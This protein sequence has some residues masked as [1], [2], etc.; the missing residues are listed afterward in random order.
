MCSGWLYGWYHN[1]TL[2]RRQTGIKERTMVS[3]LLVHRMH[4][5]HSQYIEQI[6]LRDWMEKY[7]CIAGRLFLLKQKFQINYKEL[8]IFWRFKSEKKLTN[9]YA[10][11][12]FDKCVRLMCFDFSSPETEARAIFF[13]LKALSVAIVV[14][15][16][17]H[18]NLLFFKHSA[19]FNQTYHKS[20]CCE[21]KFC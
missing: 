4:W 15:N 5:S 9:R 21:V 19:K 11:Q 16:F 14:T 3:R 8:R 17:S 10:L 1:I 7:L 12:Y 18:S 6:E 2:G 20:S 13:W